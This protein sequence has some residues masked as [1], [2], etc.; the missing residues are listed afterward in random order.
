MNMEKNSFEKEE[1]NMDD[2]IWKPEYGGH[3][4]FYT[5]FSNQAVH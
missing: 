3:L 5:I 2:L 4:F 1:V